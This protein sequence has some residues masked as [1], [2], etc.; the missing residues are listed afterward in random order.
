LIKNLEVPP[1]LSQQ[2]QE[3]QL[4]CPSKFYRQGFITTNIN[5]E[6]DATVKGASQTTERPIQSEKIR[7]LIAS[8]E[9]SLATRL[10]KPGVNDD[11]QSA[12]AT[13]ASNRHDTGSGKEQETQT[14]GLFNN[15]INDVAFV[16]ATA[17]IIRA[18]TQE[19]EALSIE[20]PRE[21]IDPSHLETSGHLCGRAPNADE[22]TAEKQGT[23]SDKPRQQ[24][25]AI[26]VVKAEEPD[27][28]KFEDPE[29]AKFGVHDDDDGDEEP[30]AGLL[31][32][33]WHE[34]LARDDGDAFSLASSW[35]SCSSIISKTEL[36][37][38]KEALNEC[39]NVALQKS[40]EAASMLSEANNRIE[41]LQQEVA[42][43]KSEQSAA[44]SDLSEI[45]LPPSDIST[46]EKTEKQQRNTY[47]LI[48]KLKPLRAPTGAL[49]PQR[50]AKPRAEQG[51][52]SRDYVELT[53]PLQPFSVKASRGYSRSQTP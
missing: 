20:V 46:P 31:A 11:A 52:K 7:G 45:P 1:P 35:S 27:V 15:P 3:Q 53:S 30:E 39:S 48:T 41:C 26:V 44:P 40:A 19:L 49:P 37:Q 12:T 43:L 50:P 16:A 17:A 13:S 42:R 5:L 51:A 47:S 32:W 18:R 22:E 34:T 29:K 33:S 8:P 2:Q 25:A 14:E 38:L 21:V 36:H 28:T 23:I 10:I 9:C 24:E 4:P 6:S